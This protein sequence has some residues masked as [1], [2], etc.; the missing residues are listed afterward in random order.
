MVDFLLNVKSRI[1]RS[2]EDGFIIKC[3]F[4]IENVRPSPFENE[5]SIVNFRYWSTEVYQTKSFIDY[6]NFNLREGNIKS[7]K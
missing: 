3:G 6:I 1:R 5:A 2:T 7:Y 4:S